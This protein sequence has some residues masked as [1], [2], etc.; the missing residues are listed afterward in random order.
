MSDAPS[1]IPYVCGECK[2]SGVRLWRPYAP[3]DAEFRLLLCRSCATR[4][5]EMRTTSEQRL[6]A[7]RLFGQTDQI[8]WLVPAVPDESGTS[9]YGYTSVPDAG[10]EWWQR[11]PC[12]VS[13]LAEHVCNSVVAFAERVIAWKNSTAAME[14][15]TEYD[16]QFAEQ[17]FDCVE[18]GGEGWLEHGG[19]DDDGDEVGPCGSCGGTGVEPIEGRLN[20]EEWMDEQMLRHARAER[21]L[22]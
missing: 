18:C 21:T 1:Q 3:T 8:G 9:F 12:E 20:R 15:F 7:E 11:L 17:E 22:P 4:S 13:T 19:P 5:H 6:S 2:A 14:E 10:I 16:E